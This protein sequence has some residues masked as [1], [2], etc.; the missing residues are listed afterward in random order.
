MPLSPIVR[1]CVSI[2]SLSPHVTTQ[3]PFWAL[4]QARTP[5][6][7]RACSVAVVNSLGNLG[8]F[9]GPF[10]L[11][12]LHDA[13]GPR[14]SGKGGVGEEGGGAGGGGKGGRGAGGGGEGGEEQCLG[15]YG[16]GLMVLALSVA[17]NAI[18]TGLWAW[19]LRLD[20]PCRE[21]QDRLGCCERGSYALSADGSSTTATH[22]ADGMLSGANS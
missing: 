4:H 16:W 10:V 18:G 12:Y 14:C 5:P 6:R 2:V 21:R 17:I 13:L 8:G 15:E 1:T 3:G 9:V 7:L 22:A 11:G 19:V 20:L